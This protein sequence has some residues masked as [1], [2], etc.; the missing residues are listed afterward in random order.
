M[1]QMYLPFVEVNMVLLFFARELALS[2]C[3]KNVLGS[4]CC[5]PNQ[6]R[7]CSTL[8]HLWLVVPLGLGKAIMEKRGHVLIDNF[9]R[10]KAKGQAALTS[11]VC[12]MSGRETRKKQY[13]PTFI[14][15]S[16]RP[17]DSSFEYELIMIARDLINQAL[18]SWQV[19]G[20]RQTMFTALFNANNRMER[21]VRQARVPVKFSLKS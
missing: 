4:A 5:I 6:D 19:L 2:F 14:A 12:V 16:R 7:A 8:T 20:H 21:S 1:T 13:L 9:K 17:N 18:L 11:C 10:K 3:H 15:L